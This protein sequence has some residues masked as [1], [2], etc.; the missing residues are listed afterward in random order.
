MIKLTDIIKD[1]LKENILPTTLA[2]LR[3][4]YVGQIH[5]PTLPIQYMMEFKNSAPDDFSALRQAEDFLVARKYIVGRLE[6]R[7]SDWFR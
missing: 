1:I 2:K 3:P 5:L 4:D 6:G 7:F